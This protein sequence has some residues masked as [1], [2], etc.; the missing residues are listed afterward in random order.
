MSVAGDGIV[1]F[2]RHPYYIVG[3]LNA[4]QVDDL[5]RLYPKRL[6]GDAVI[7]RINKRCEVMGAEDG[8]Y[9]AVDIDHIHDVAN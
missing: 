1:Y 6:S 5:I 9:E 2:D 7:A 3:P 4:W 8:T